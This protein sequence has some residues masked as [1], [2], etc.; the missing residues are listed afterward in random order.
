MAERG[1]SAAHWREVAQRAEGLGY[2]TL[3]MPDHITDQLAPVA[4]PSA[5]MCSNTRRGTTP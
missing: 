2:D 1:R 4:P 5:T 3:L